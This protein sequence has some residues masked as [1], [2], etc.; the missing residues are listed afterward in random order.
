[1]VVMRLNALADERPQLIDFMGPHPD[2]MFGSTRN[3]FGRPSKA[4]ISSD[5]IDPGGATAIGHSACPFRL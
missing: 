5:F 1:M 2:P 3:T 4:V